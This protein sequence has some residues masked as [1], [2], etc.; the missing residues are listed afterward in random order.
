MKLKKN[1]LKIIKTLSTFMN[2]SIGSTFKWNP[3]SFLFL[4]LSLSLNMIL[5]KLIHV[6]ISQGLSE[7]QNHRMNMN[8]KG[9][10]LDWFIGDHLSSP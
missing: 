9:D 6:C 4:Q 7:E 2:L 10:L 3:V 1:N 5:L 8:C